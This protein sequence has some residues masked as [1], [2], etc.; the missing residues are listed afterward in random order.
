MSAESP[1][2][3]VETPAEWLRYANE[4]LA[5]AERELGYDEPAF[6]TICFLC[7]SAAEKYLKGFLYAWPHC[8]DH[9]LPK[10]KWCHRA[11]TTEE[12]WESTTVVAA[13]GTGGKWETRRNGE[14]STY[15]RSQQPPCGNQCTSAGVR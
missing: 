12:A 14:F 1:R 5:V 2:R 3:P 9:K 6:H 8:Q 15:P 4:N 11:R 10:L 7:Q 13:V